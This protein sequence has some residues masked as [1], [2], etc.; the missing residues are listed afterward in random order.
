MKSPQIP[1]ARKT[2]AAPRQ[3]Q[4]CLRCSPLNLRKQFRTQAA[5]HLVANHLFNLQHAFHIYNKQEGK[6]TIDTLLL[7]KDSDNWWK[8][9]INELGR[10]ANGIDN[11]VRATNT[12]KYIINEEVPRYQQVAQLHM[13]ILCMITDHLNNNHTESY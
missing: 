8:A 9:V 5:Q 12:I 2:Q 1:K 7:G 13:P 4:H 10:L 3:V 6:E 11:Q